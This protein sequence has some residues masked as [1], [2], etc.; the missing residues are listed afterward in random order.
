[1]TSLYRQVTS[2]ANSNRVQ[3]PFVGSMSAPK[4]PFAFVL[5]PLT[6]YNKIRCLCS[7]MCGARTMPD[8]GL[9]TDHE[10][11]IGALGFSVFRLVYGCGLNKE[12]QFYRKI[13]FSKLP[14]GESGLS[15]AEANGSPGPSLQIRWVAAI[16]IFS[17]FHHLACASSLNCCPFFS[18]RM[19]KRENRGLGLRV[20]N[21]SSALKI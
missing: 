14:H 13:I 7:A 4:L 11:R 20:S 5:S 21:W 15:K 8:L 12:V 16:S 18:L 17:G 3:F 6:R 2:G 19:N 9:L 10:V 1:M